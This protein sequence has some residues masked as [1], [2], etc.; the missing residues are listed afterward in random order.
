MPILVRIVLD[1]NILTRA[2]TGPGGPAAEVLRAIVPPHLRIASP[3]LLAGLKR[4]IESVQPPFLFSRFK[5][6]LKM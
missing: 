1:T 3:Y 4:A 6:I 2:V 5:C